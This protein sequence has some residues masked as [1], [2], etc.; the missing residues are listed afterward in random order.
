MDSSISKN[1]KRSLNTV[2]AG[3][4][5]APCLQIRMEKLPAIHRI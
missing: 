4:Q 5:A 1:K 3:I 2:S